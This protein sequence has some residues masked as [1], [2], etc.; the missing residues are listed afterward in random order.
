LY[1]FHKKIKSLKNPKKPI[2]SVFLG[3]FFWMGFL[4]PTL[5]SGP[6]ASAA[7]GA[8]SARVTSSGQVGGESGG[9]G[10]QQLLLLTRESGRQEFSE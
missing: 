7:E 10:H 4:L 2:F 8:K 6:A 3:G 5:E 1:Y 9:A